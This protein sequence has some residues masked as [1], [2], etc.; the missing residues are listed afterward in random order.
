MKIGLTYVDVAIP[1]PVHHPYTYHVPAE[2]SALV[3]AGKR[4]LVSFG[5]RRVTG[6]V[7][8]YSVDPGDLKT[9]PILD[10]LDAKPL[11]P[12]SLIPFFKW[13]ADYYMYPIG[14]AI[15]CA[16]PSGLNR[17]DFDLFH[18]TPKGRG[19]L[20]KK[21]VSN[22]QRLV[23]NCLEASPKAFRAI[24][25]DCHHTLSK[26]D[27]LMME[28]RGWVG[29]TKK[30]S[31]QKSKPKMGR[32]VSIA[33]FDP[34]TGGQGTAKARI[35][36]ELIKQGEM[37][38][39]ALTE[40]IPSASRVIR[41][42]EQENR[43]KICEKPLYR[44]PFGEPIIPDVRHDLTEDQQKAIST[45]FPS[46]DQ[47]FS[48]YLLAGVT[49]SGKTEVYMQTV[50]EVI[51]RGLSAL[52]LVPEIALISQ[53]GRSFRSRF[54]DCVALLHS[55]LTAGERYD[56][57]IRILSKQ[58]SIAIGARSAIFAP[59]S[60]VG[61][62]VVDE[63]HDTS[64]KQEN[65][66]R[67]NARDLAMVRARHHGCVVLMG[68]AT[69][70]IQSYYNVS[71]GKFKLLRLPNRIEDR[72]LPKVRVVDLKK[73][74]SHRGARRFITPMLMNAMKRTLEKREQVL[75][76]LNRR[77]YAS[78]PTCAACSEPVKCNNCDISLTHHQTTRAFVCH[79]CGFTRAATSPCQACGSPKIKLLGLGTE[80]VEAA[81]KA[82]FPE[83]NVARMDRDTTRRKGA[84]LKLLKGLKNRSI[85]VLIGT[86]IIT[87]GHHFSDITL[88]G[89]IS[90]DLSLN[91]PDFR[92]GE[93]TF[94][95]LAQV[96]GRAGRG[97]SPGKVVLQTYNPEH[98]TIA[99][100]RNQD[101]TQFYSQEIQ[102]RRLLQYPP[103]SR[104]IRV[105]ISGKNSVRTE[106][107]AKALGSRCTELKRCKQAFQ[108]SIDILGPIESP[109][110]KIANRY[111]WQILLKG[112]HVKTLHQFSRALFFQ[113]N[114]QG[115]SYQV[116]TVIDVD[117]YFMM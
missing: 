89:I 62:I 107:E 36:A 13:I 43:V 60:D 1:R 101:F 91:F 47:G 98:F 35:I 20:L 42:L 77:G 25:K 8:G 59:L 7:L 86:Q 26:S 57:W 17:F 56:Q 68:S 69:P 58:A 103:F 4:V 117:P 115:K 66:L 63:E 52:V 106:K 14:Q 45:I 34:D 71:T 54:G 99:A 27:L 94:Q 114:K 84:I 81:V 109:L 24:V 102:H 5:S 108:D 19:R 93:R 40:Q 48:T 15:Q 80:K 112:S 28:R 46:L 95:L 32:F 100:A 83:A 6:Y 72:P 110:S 50:A 85:D 96:S 67:Y 22:Q 12:E 61:L 16:L 3:T 87:K 2:L 104:M 11:F 9:K 51:N 44:D 78:F 92:A 82:L 37:S 70:S 65:Q 79:Y 53:I 88:V 116:S 31:D 111:R 18:I 21:K 29:K 90:A 49:G 41:T 55:G 75:L 33:E 73:S 38:V 23:L 39:K 10:V 30:L 74:K 113:P 97:P 76:F 64:Y 105:Q